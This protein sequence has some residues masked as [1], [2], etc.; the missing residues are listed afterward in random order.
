MCIFAERIREYMKNVVLI[1][2]LCLVVVM[3]LLCL[4]YYNRWKVLW[5]LEKP[6]P[7]YAIHHY[8]DDT[9]RVVMIGDSWIEMHSNHGLDSL[10]EK[11]LC[12]LTSRP[13]K[14]SSKGKGGMRS[15]GIYD[16]MFKSKGYGTKPVIVSGA[17]YCVISAGIND[18]SANLGTR[19]YCHYMRLII[20]FLLENEIRPV[21]I[22]A[23]DVNIWKLFAQRP[24]KNIAIDSLRSI[25]TGCGMY[26]YAEYREALRKSLKDGQLK[27]S[28]VFVSMYGWDGNGTAMDESLFLDDQIH[29]NRKGYELLDSCIASAIASDIHNK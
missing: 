10:L 22:E 24:L 16:L 6:R 14:V 4:Y 23:P 12:E 25:M 19:Q 7:V 17:D 21:I 29:L 13:V 28:V 20:D 15:R 2:F 3:L 8:S 26:H 5:E 11:Q 9:L 18:A 27:D 1:G